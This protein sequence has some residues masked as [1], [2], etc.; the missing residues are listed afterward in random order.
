MVGLLAPVSMI[1]YGLA[2]YNASSYTIADIKYLGLLLITLGLIGAI[3][4]DY[5]VI[6]WAVG[7]GLL[8]MIYCSYI[9]FRYERS[10][11]R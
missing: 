10:G 2:L 11:D 4:V 7:F 9:Y 8:H 6:L 1:F 5:G 3:A